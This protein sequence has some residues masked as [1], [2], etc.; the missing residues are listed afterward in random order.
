MCQD[1]LKCI[2]KIQM[3]DNIIDCEDESDEDE[4]IC[5]FNALQLAKVT[6]RF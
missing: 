5:H 2:E 3:C 4:L 1:E 6:F